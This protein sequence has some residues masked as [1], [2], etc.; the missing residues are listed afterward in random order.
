MGAYSMINELTDGT[1]KICYAT[2]SS[3]ADSNEDFE[4]LA[5]EIQIIEKANG[6]AS[7]TMETKTIGVGGTAVVS[8]MS[9]R[10]YEA[11]LSTDTDWIGIYKKGDCAEPDL[12]QDSNGVTPS[13]AN[14][15]VEVDP[16]NR[17]KCYVEAQNVGGGAT[18]GQVKFNLKY[19]RPGIRLQAHR[20]FWCE[21]IPAVRLA[22]LGG[23]RCRDGD[24]A[25][26]PCEFQRGD[27]PGPRGHLPTLHVLSQPPGRVW[28]GLGAALRPYKAARFG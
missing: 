11:K 9:T 1:Y 3:E 10:G 4:D 16:T 22:G 28:L 13:I 12:W 23:E 2:K 21:H 17:H 5:R 25:E 6:H 18:S 27:H 19:A 20:G 7:V 24:A 8:W 26:F 15:V 14:R